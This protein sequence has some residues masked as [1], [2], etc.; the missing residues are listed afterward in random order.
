MSVSR[1]GFFDDMT[2]NNN[3]LHHACLLGAS[4]ESVNKILIEFSI[5][6]IHQRFNTLSAGM[7][8]RVSLVLP[9]IRK[10]TLVFLDEPTNHLDIDSILL[11][12]QTILREKKNNKASF[13]I[14]SHILSDLEKVCDRILF[15]KDGVIVKNSL[16]HLLLEEYG[17]LE[18]AYIEILQAP[19]K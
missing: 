18:E 11:L 10:N 19:K 16:T 14:T 6:Y 12:R 3:L 5:D 4:E 17:N 15:L 2:V 13:L 9:F 7:K 1:K 8:Q